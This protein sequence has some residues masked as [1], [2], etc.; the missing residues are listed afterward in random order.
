MNR[1]PCRPAFGAVSGRTTTSLP[2]KALSTSWRRRRQGSGRVPAGDAGQDAAPKG[3]ARTCSEEIRLGA[4]LLAHARAVASRRKWRSAASSRPS[5]RWKSIRRRGARAADHQRG[6]TRASRSTQTPSSPSCKAGLIF[7]LT[8]ALYGEIT[9]DKGRVQQRNFN[10][11]RMLRID[12]APVHRC[13]SH[14]EWRGAGGI[15]ETGTTAA[16]PAVRNAIYAATG[17]ALRRLPFD[18]EVWRGGRRHELVALHDHRHRRHA[19]V[20]L[21]VFLWIV[22]GPGP[23]DFAPGERVA[24]AD[25]HDANPTGVPASLANASLIQRGEYLTRA[26]DCQ[27][28]HTAKGGAPFAG[29]LAFNAIDR[30]IYSLNITPD[31]DTGIG[32]LERCRFPNALR[33]RR[34]RRGRTALPGDSRT[35]P[36]TNMTDADA[37][38]IKAYLVFPAAGA[39]RKCRPLR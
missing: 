25:Y 38:A 4:A 15:G 5:P 17:I 8:A 11:Y 20:F 21:A 33:I 30:T 13:A 28:C 39:Q 3:G 18:R 16:P 23:M 36:T 24:L 7:G 12:Q 27:A 22:L 35:P 37:L 9:I 26:A 10:D 2:L 19:V 31:K 6:S 32:R 1:P 29:G 34:R 14:S